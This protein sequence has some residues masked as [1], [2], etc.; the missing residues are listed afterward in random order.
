MKAMAWIVLVLLVVM[1]ASGCIM[2]EA[3]YKNYTSAY[4]A[5]VNAVAN[6]G[7][8]Y[9]DKD[10]KVHV[11]Q[12]QQRKACEVKAEQDV[13]LPKGISFI[14]YEHSGSDSK[15]LAMAFLKPPQQPDYSGLYSLSATTISTIGNVSVWGLGLHAATKIV[16]VLSNN[17]GHNVNYQYGDYSGNGR[18]GYESNV[19]TQYGDYSGNG[20]NGFEDSS[21]HSI[22][23][24]YNTTRS[25]NDSYDTTDDHSAN[26][27]YNPVT[28]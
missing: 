1:G 8:V 4:T 20:R 7:T 15:A 26:S 23:D 16:D 27:S 2:T 24:S 12:A 9:T 5:Y 28:P 13:V 21:N 19:T 18:N 25:I 6:G 11:V 22:N 14:C 17:A 10:G 3:Q